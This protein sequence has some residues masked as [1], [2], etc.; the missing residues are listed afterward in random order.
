MIKE[1]H[2][3]KVVG[4]CFLLKGSVEELGLEKG[5]YELEN[6]TCTSETNR[7]EFQSIWCERSQNDKSSLEEM[8]RPDFNWLKRVYISISD[9][10]VKMFPE[11]LRMYEHSVVI[12][13]KL[14]LSVP[15]KF[16]K[17]VWAMENLISAEATHQPLK[18]K[19]IMDPSDTSRVSW[20]KLDTLTGAS[21]FSLVEYNELDNGMFI[22]HDFGK[23]R[24]NIVWVLPTLLWMDELYKPMRADEVNL[25]TGRLNYIE[26]DYWVSQKGT[27]CFKPKEGGKHL[28]IRDDWGGSPSEHGSGILK[29]LNPI[30]YRYAPTNSGR[31]GRDFCVIEKGTKYKPNIEEI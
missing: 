3:E 14:H 22:F 31:S 17:E 20:L 19:L 2:V 27:K 25:H 18:M 15:D 16:I 6:Y 11:D 12:K 8:N 9:E 26:G 29:Q 30:Y 23:C 28:L 13:G 10:G 24:P 4:T 1:V 21:I 5:V 7:R